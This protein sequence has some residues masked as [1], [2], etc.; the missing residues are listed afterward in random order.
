MVTARG[1]N[2]TSS[3]TH[4]KPFLTSISAAGRLNNLSTAPPRPNAQARASTDQRERDQVELAHRL[5]AA[6]GPLEE[7]WAGS[8]FFKILSSPLRRCAMTSHV[9]P[10]ELMLQLKP[11]HLPA[12]PSSYDDGGD[13][14]A[15]GKG[16][17]GKKREAAAQVMLPDQLL[18]P[19]Y[20]AKKKGK[21]LWITLNPTILEE[22]ELRGAYKSAAPQARFPPGL[23]DFITQQ[24]HQR[25]A[26]EAEMMRNRLLC[27]SRLD[28]ARRL[29]SAR[30]HTQAQAQEAPATPLPGLTIVKTTSN[31]LPAL[32][33]SVDDDGRPI[34]SF[35]VLF[36]PTGAEG[37]VSPLCSFVS[38][39]PQPEA[40]HDA[41]SVP[42]YNLSSLPPE[43]QQSIRHHLDAIYSYETSCDDTLP[44]PSTTAPHPDLDTAY[45]ILQSPHTVDVA[46][47]LWRLKIWNSA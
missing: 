19:R 8:A 33:E 14:K 40:Q 7:R 29:S 17:G 45:A 44:T 43:L 1:T 21:G 13:G 9:L 39:P 10:K 47:A 32:L 18:H 16:S 12:S 24:L 35:A 23:A 6:I 41:L 2:I 15:K 30:T 25:V 20:S 46:V 22:V 28:V 34:Y 27:H 37:S 3:I 36:Q 4:G 26:Q 31:A 42:T 11:V 5:R 38:S